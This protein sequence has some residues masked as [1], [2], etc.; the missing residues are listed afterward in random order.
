MKKIRLLLVSLTI[1]V[2]AI[3]SFK[4]I[5][6]AAQVTKIN[7]SKGQIYIDQGKDAGFIFGAKVCFFSSIDK[8]L[9]CGKVLRATDSYAI[10]RIRNRRKTKEIEIGSEAMLH[11][12]KENKE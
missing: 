2:L 7:E 8:E 9:I 10:V 4:D 5:C 12:E 3:P 1:I 6:G 11:V